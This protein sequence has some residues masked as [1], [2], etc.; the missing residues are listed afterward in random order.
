MKRSEFI[1]VGLMTGVTAGLFNAAVVGVGGSLG[2]S[3]SAETDCA[4]MKNEA[5]GV[6]SSDYV[7]PVDRF[8]DDGS[9]ISLDDLCYEQQS[10]IHTKSAETRLNEQIVIGSLA[11]S[12]VSCTALVVRRVAYGIPVFDVQ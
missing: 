1:Q 6:Y 9:F 12:A 4:K 11:L 7:P 3:F 2:N 8:R 5:V 10:S